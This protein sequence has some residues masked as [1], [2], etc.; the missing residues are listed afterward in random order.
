MIS[1]INGFKPLEKCIS[2]LD[3][4]LE[5]INAWFS[6]QMECT[7]KIIETDFNPKNGYQVL[8]YLK[9]E[10]SLLYLKECKN[11]SLLSKTSCRTV[12]HQLEIYLQGYSTLYKKKWTQ[13]L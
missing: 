5:K 3:T 8:D 12:L 6:E 2:N 13:L 10:E 7:F 11:L 9:A 1:R 4:L